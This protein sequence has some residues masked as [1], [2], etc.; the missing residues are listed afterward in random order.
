[1]RQSAF[2]GGAT[3]EHSASVT[4]LSDS[5]SISSRRDDVTPMA[6]SSPHPAD[7]LAPAVSRSS[8]LPNMAVMT[9]S[10]TGACPATVVNPAAVRLCMQGSLRHKD[11]IIL[12]KCK[13]RQLQPLRPARPPA[14]DAR[15]LTMVA[16]ERKSHRAREVAVH[17]VDDD[18]DKPQPRSA[19]RDLGQ[20]RGHSEVTFPYAGSGTARWPK[21]SRNYRAEEM[22]SLDCGV[23]SDR[24]RW[25]TSIVASSVDLSRSPR[26]LLHCQLQ[27]LHP[28]PS[29]LPIHPIYVAHPH[30]RHSPTSECNHIH[31]GSTVS[32]PCIQALFPRHGNSGRAVVH[33]N[34]QRRRVYTLAR[35]YSERVRQLQRTSS[36]TTHDDDRFHV[37]ASGRMM[38]AR[39]ATMQPMPPAILHR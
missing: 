8:S 4:S 7:E 10:S 5:L 6:S 15:P 24:T 3:I 22:M 18:R 12:R 29:L 23:Q 37:A 17:V 25:R 1:M 26:S 35:A 14:G 16:T 33:A 38:P 39:R 21:G 19:N 28:V 20:G 34:P 31:S 9:S 36:W 13:L 11:S 32:Y 2:A 27:V 30:V